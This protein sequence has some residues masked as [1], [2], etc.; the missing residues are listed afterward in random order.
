MRSPYSERKRIRETVSLPLG[1]VRLTKEFVPGDPPTEEELARLKQFIARE[2][3]K[4]ERRFGA[5]R[6]SL[7]IATSG[8]AAALAEA[9]QAMRKSKAAGA[10]RVARGKPLADTRNV[11]RLTTKLTGMTNA[12]RSSVPGIGPKRSEIVVA[13]AHVYA[14]LLER[15]ALP[16]FIYSTLG[17]RDGILTQMLAEQDAKTTAHQQFER[18]R[19]Q[20]VLAT[21]K[22]YGVDPRQAD[23]G[24]PART[25]TLPRSA[26]GA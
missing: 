21:C 18:E 15:F 4:A 10:A 2:L 24:T 19:W 23:A 5:L 25:A 22:L 1:A 11:R 3:R 26:G 14:E 20:G 12:Q 17:L 9:S 6:V 16:G 7:V 13:G 8:T